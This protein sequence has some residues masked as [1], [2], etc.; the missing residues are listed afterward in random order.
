MAYEFD[1]CNDLDTLGTISE[2]LKHINQHLAGS[3]STMVTSLQTSQSFLSGKQY[4]KAQVATLSSIEL[5]RI[6]VNTLDQVTNKIADLSGIIGEYS[7]CC[8]QG[9]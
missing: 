4:E 7:Q 9:E 5:T 8:Y 6:T 1:V 3:V 2:K